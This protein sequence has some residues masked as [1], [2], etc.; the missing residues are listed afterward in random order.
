M[1]VLRLW[2]YEVFF[3]EKRHFFIENSDYFQTPENLFF[4]Q[5]MVDPQVGL[6]LTGKLGHWGIG[7]LAGD[8]RAAGELLPEEDSLHDTRAAIGAFRLYRELGKESR[9][10]DV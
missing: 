6:R 1:A 8:D 2:R 7:T 10:S 9:D 4:S 3:P 5:R